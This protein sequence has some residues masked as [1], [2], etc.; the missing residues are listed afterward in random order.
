MKV[1]DKV[2]IINYGHNVHTTI[3]LD[4][5]ENKTTFDLLPFLLGSEGVIQEIQTND[6]RC[7]YKIE[8]IF[9]KKCWYNEDQLE[10][11]Q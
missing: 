2:R 4:V 7:F 6:D 8:G 5:Y 10:L 11:I 3:K 9:D 1:G